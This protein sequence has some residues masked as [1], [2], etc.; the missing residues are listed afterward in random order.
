MNTTT[1]I[2]KKRKSKHERA[3][4]WFGFALTIPAIIVLCVVVALPIM[5]GVYCS[6]FQYKAADLRSDPVNLEEIPAVLS[7]EKDAS[8]LTNYKWNNFKNY[9]TLL[10][11]KYLSSD[12]FNL[13]KF[14]E[15]S[16]I[17]VYLGNTLVFVF[18]TVIIQTVLGMMI[19]LLLNSKIKGQGLMRG[20]FLIPWTIPS[21]VVAIMW[22]L[23]LHESG[24][25]INY[26]LNLFGFVPQT[27]ISW[28]SSIGTAR[29]SIV[30]AS[31]WRQMPYMMV[32]I[33]AALQSVDRS[34]VEA[35]QIDGASG[36][37]AFR[38][39][40]LP[41]IT[42][43]LIT[44]VWIAVMNN[45]QMYTIIA[46]LAG[47]GSNTGTMTLSIAAYETAFTNKDYGQGAA[48]GVIWLLLLFVITLLANRAS[49]KS[50]RDYQ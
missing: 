42:P 4:S 21:V 41:A 15:K 46:N 14:F 10:K 50:A 11:T 37:Q 18:F 26:M 13:K 12:N 32:M 7:G 9:T 29:A 8:A 3:D 25:V 39:V 31:V 44:S 1:A 33:L 16:D 5:K 36:W 38:H 43:V 2:R 19:A 17:L 49:E 20:L 48:I 6:L 34:Q 27:S 22:R 40:T 30:M 28:L 45:F 47:R 24:G 35:A 23:M